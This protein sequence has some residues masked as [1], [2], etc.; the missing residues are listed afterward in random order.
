M[1]EVGR[2]GEGGKEKERKGKRKERRKEERK[3]SDCLQKTFRTQNF[4]SM[5]M[6]LPKVQ[7]S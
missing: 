1:R 2:G 4:K 7:P 6:K 3:E 5:R